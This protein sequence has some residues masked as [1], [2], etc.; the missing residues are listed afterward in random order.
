M[1]LGDRFKKGGEVPRENSFHIV[2]PLYSSLVCFVC[3]PSGY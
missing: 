1:Q 3:F 2:T